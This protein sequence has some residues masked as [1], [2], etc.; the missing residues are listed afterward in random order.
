MD[1]FQRPTDWTGR[2]LHFLL[3]AVI[4]SFIGFYGWAR[5]ASENPRGWMIIAIA[6][7]VLGVLGAVWG[8]RFWF[9]V[10]KVFRYWWLP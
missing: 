5:F 6:A 10:S 1:E 8:D 2:I 7:L 3:G 4:G 9:R